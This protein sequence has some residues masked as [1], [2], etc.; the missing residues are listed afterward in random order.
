VGRRKRWRWALVLA[1]L[2]YVGSYL[3]LSRVGFA[4]ADQYGAKGFY[5][6]EP[7]DTRLWRL[8]NSTCVC[9]YCPLIIID[10]WLGTGRWPGSEPLWGLDR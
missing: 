2:C 3:A 9:V 5:F 1:L 10:N 7:R 4:W 8:E 6:V